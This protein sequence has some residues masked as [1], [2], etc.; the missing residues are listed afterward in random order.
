M[1][2]EWCVFDVPPRDWRWDLSLVDVWVLRVRVARRV[3]ES[4]GGA[5]CELERWVVWIESFE[6]L[7]VCLLE[8]EMMVKG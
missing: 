8:A 4:G 1:G 3:G 2:E 7:G 5:P 6:V